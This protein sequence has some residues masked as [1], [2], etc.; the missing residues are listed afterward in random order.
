MGNEH[1]EKLF[2]GG[3]ANFNGNFI[4][5][6]YLDSQTIT[7]RTDSALLICENNI[8][9]I[10]NIVFTKFNFIIIS[11]EVADE[12]DNLNIDKKQKIFKANEIISFL[13]EGD[14]VELLSHDKFSRIFILYRIESDSNIIIATNHCNNKCIMCPQPIY[15]SEDDN[16][17]LPKIEKVVSM[18]DKQTKFL[19]ITGGEPTLLKEGL[20]QI[21]R[22]CK[23]Y[24]PNTKIAILT[25]GRMFSYNSLV[26]AINS[27][28]L[29]FLE[30]GIPIHSYD[31]EVHD[32]ITQTPN[33]FNQTIIGIKNLTTS[34]NN[35]EIRIVIQ[36]NNYLVLNKIADFIISEIPEINRVSFIGMEMLGSAVKNSKAV[37]VTYQK[38]G[39][40]LK[41]AILK[42]L[43]HRIKVNI[44]NI[45][46]CK[47]DKDLK[48][49]CAKSISD[50]KI[51]YL[52][53]CEL[54]NEK[55]NCGGIFVS[56]LN[57]VKQEGVNP[58]I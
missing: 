23:S 40:N 2:Y 10:K 6:I 9:N 39:S 42:L 45:P 38:I 31:E 20:I 52:S 5:K 1:A 57:F 48:P 8:N 30:I 19:T 51:R 25:N 50:Y 26:D 15:I 28:G 12:I 58:F 16:V 43:M 49:L 56:S 13:N 33:S 55:E 34:N 7:N 11:S 36:K 44:Y 14:I 54:C 24:L 29:K 41:E 37:W 35:I 47:V 27:V 17:N 53:E 18:M 22:L 32:Y 3:E 46:L 21:L 4:V